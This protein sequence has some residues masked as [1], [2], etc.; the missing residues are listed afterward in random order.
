MKQPTKE[1]IREK[2]ILFLNKNSEFG[3]LECDC[4]D[5]TKFAQSLFQET[6]GETWKRVAFEPQSNSDSDFIVAF[7]TAQRFHQERKRIENGD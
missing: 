2:A 1:E 6:E 7:K 5:L 4:D 3:L